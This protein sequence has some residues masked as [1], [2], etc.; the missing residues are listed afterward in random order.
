MATPIP[1]LPATQICPMC[2][3][4]MH[5]DMDEVNGQS[6][7]CFNRASEKKPSDCH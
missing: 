4:Q 3:W 7:A 2:A 1:K 5:R 6:S